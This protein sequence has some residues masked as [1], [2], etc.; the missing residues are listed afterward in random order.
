VPPP[1][2][3]GKHPFTLR[4]Q[5]DRA[6]GA[7]QEAEMPLVHETTWKHVL[8][9]TPQELIERQ[10]QESFPVLMKGVSPST[11][12]WL[13]PWR[14]WQYRVDG[15]ARHFRFAPRAHFLAGN[16]VPP[17]QQARTAENGWSQAQ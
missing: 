7:G 16:S 4:N 10:S 17:H 15:L 12:I 9:E 1:G 11:S 8:H 5:V 3:S 2:W 13:N 14:A 6:A